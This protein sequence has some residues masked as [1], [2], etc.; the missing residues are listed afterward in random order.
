MIADELNKLK[1]TKAAIKQALIDKGQN[2]TDEFASYVGNIGSISSGEDP[3]LPLGYPMPSAFQVYINNGLNFKET[4]DPNGSKYL[5]IPSVMFL[6][7]G[8]DFSKVISVSNW[9]KLLYVPRLDLPNY[10]SGSTLGLANAFYVELGTINPSGTFGMV[11]GKSLYKCVINEPIK[12]GNQYSGANVFNG[13]EGLV[14]IVG[15][16]NLDVSNVSSY[17]KEFFKNCKSLKGTLDLTFWNVSNFTSFQYMFAYTGLS[18]I[19]ISTWDTSKATNMDYMFQSQENLEEVLL[20][21]NFGASATTMGR[22]FSGCYS[23]KSIDFT[24]FNTSNVGKMYDMNSMFGSCKSLEVIDLST[25]DISKVMDMDSMFSGC[26]SLKTLILPNTIPTSLYRSPSQMIGNCPALEYVKVPENNPYLLSLNSSTTN[27]I[28]IDGSFDVKDNVGGKEILPYFTK[29]RKVTLKGLG[30]PADCEYFS[31]SKFPW[32][33]EDPEDSRTQGAKQSLIDS[34]ITYS[35]DRATAGYDKIGIYLN[36]NTTKTILT[37]EEIAQMTAK[38]YSI[39][40][41]Y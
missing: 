6:P 33:V 29:L 17:G 38:G 14:E 4:Y 15:I 9:D 2:P 12:I 24:K 25:W 23:L 31:L 30:T 7:T 5:T 37:E 11:F 18:K 22:M 34:L 32:G 39:I 19:D 8:M 20:P 28:A 41:S 35:F 3:F 16:E 1:Q 40:F 21:D 26:T 36:R 13:C 10:N 27:V